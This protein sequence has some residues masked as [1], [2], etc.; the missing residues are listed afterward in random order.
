MAKVDTISD[1]FYVSTFYNEKGTY[2]VKQSVPGSCAINLF[3][4]AI[5]EHLL[6]TNAEKQL[7]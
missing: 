1:W 3:A 7:P 2:R 6:D 5:E 4:K